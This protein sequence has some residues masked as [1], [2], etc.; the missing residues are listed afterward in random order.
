MEEQKKKIESELYY[1]Y[2]EKFYLLNRWILFTEGKIDRNY[3]A[4]YYSDLHE[5]RQKIEDQ[6]YIRN[7]KE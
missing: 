3:F 5:V 6:E 2:L 1:V 4:E 7:Y